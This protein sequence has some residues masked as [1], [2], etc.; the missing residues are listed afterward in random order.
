MLRA[1][2]LG[3]GARVRV[4]QTMCDEHESFD[5]GFAFGLSLD[6]LQQGALVR[7]AQCVVGRGGTGTVR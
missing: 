4:R 6:V 3:A 5:S 7:F 1:M 2:P